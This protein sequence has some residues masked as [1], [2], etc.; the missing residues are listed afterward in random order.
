MHLGFNIDV[1]VDPAD[2]GARGDRC[3][4]GVRYSDNFFFFFFFLFYMG[5]IVPAMRGLV[6][7][8]Q[9]GGNSQRRATRDP[10]RTGLRG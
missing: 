6:D 9:A 10:A 5:R 3:Q 8:Q 2:G 1:T 7:T 4:W